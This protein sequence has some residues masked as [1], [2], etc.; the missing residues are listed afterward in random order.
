MEDEAK[1]FKKHLDDTSEIDDAFTGLKDKL[2]QMKKTADGMLDGT[3]ADVKEI[4]AYLSTIN[5][6]SE[7]AGDSAFSTIEEINLR[8]KNLKI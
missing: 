4:L 2:E 5:A 6:A 3:E 1:N 8:E 7:Q